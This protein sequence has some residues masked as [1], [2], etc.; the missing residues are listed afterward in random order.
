MN[1][2]IK[3]SDKF[4]IVIIILFVTAL[5]AF[6]SFCLCQYFSKGIVEERRKRQR[7]QQQT[8]AEVDRLFRGWGESQNVDQSGNERN[9]DITQVDSRNYV[10]TIQTPIIVHSSS[11]NVPL[12]H[13]SLY[14][15]SHL[16]PTP[17]NRSRSPSPAR[18]P[19][20][21][22]PNDESDDLPP[23][24]DFAIHSSTNNLKMHHSDL[25]SDI[26]KH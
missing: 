8:R 22:A 26:N 3:T 11:Y 17:V 5:V 14:Y 7:D 25:K 23:S 6:I 24:Y 12:N 20:P 1:S 18:F 10:S 2:L 4:I 13:G 15:N 16:L 19:K 21:T 9:G